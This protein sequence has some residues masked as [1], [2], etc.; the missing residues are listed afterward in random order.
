MFVDSDNNRASG[1]RYALWGH[2]QTSTSDPA[3]PTVWV[4]TN[5]ASKSSPGN[6]G[7]RHNDAISASFAD[8][9]AKLIRTPIA[10]SHSTDTRLHW[11]NPTT[12]D[13]TDLN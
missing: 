13:R 11:A 3:D 12:L 4:L 1:S 8:G 5:D 10:N 9:H 2:K 7:A 6:A